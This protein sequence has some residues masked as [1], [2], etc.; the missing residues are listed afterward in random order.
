MGARIGALVGGDA[1]LHLARIRVLLDHGFNNYDPFVAGQYFFPIYHTNLH[2]AL[3]AACSQLTGIHHFGVWF[4]SLAWGKLL[5]AAG[6]YYMVWCVFDRR[7]VGYVAAVFMVG[8]QGPVNF[9]VYPNKLA[10]LWIVPFMIGFAIQAC[11][12]PCTWTSSLKLGMG[13]LVLGQLHSLY[14]AFA[15]IV[16]GPV[17]SVVALVRIL[18]RREDRWRLAACTAALTAALPFL[19]VTK[20]TSNPKSRSSPTAQAETK[21]D[22]S[23]GDAREG[24]VTMGPRSG[25]GTV[26]DWRSACLGVGIVCALVGSRRKEAAIFLAIA[27][28][29]ALIFY[30]P[31]LCT[32]ALR[33][34]E[35]KW[36]LGRMGFVL[37]LGFIGLVPASVA[38]LIEPKTR[39]AWVR[40]L[41]SVLVLLFAVAFARHK[42]PNTWRIYWPKATASLAE[43]ENYLART[44]LVV[45]FCRKHIP[46]GVTV[47]VD[48]WS[49]MV[50]TAV[51]DCYIVAPRR[52]SLGIP[53]VAQRRRD[54]ETMLAADTT[55]ETRRPLL[56]K[57][58][59][60]YF[61]PAGTPTGWIEGH[62]KEQ[63]T[64]PGIRLFILD[65]DR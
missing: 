23:S 12:S 64:E 65:T 22:G 17:L 9:V 35:K 45:T 14:G 33:V 19:L 38:F 2:H 49:G 13:S 21:Q 20:F 63:R 55:W 59:I 18:R 27:G 30:V 34:F 56:R 25:W 41:L 43:R 60:K 48:E 52:G 10:P 40:S 54:L 51:H 32:A 28:I 26:R 29:A 46:R 24:W 15:G 39:F 57:Y 7:W 4:A 53:G 50:L 3:Y 16:L 47:L 31:P 61:F 37:Y 6:S 8:C 58:G 11:R 36:I 42:E 62:V 1:V 44:R 5:I